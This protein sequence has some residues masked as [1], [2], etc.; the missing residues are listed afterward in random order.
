MG[1][2]PTLLSLAG[3][4]QAMCFNFMLILHIR[5]HP[6]YQQPFGP[7]AQCSLSL[8]QSGISP[9]CMEY[10]FMEIVKIINRFQNC[11]YS[12]SHFW[13]RK[14]LHDTSMCRKN[15]GTVDQRRNKDFLCV[16]TV[17]EH[18]LFLICTFPPK[19]IL[20]GHKIKIIK[21]KYFEK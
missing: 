12:M 1:I 21:M 14:K 7:I 5:H 17:E 8:F 3:I 18:M 20:P 13:G 15:Y 4:C 6:C 19:T 9:M 16:V 10:M 11:V 2:L